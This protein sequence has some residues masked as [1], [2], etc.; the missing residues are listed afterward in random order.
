MTPSILDTSDEAREPVKHCS[1]RSR[2]HIALRRS[3]HHANDNMAPRAPHH[4]A[5]IRQMVRP[6]RLD[7]HRARI[8]IHAREDPREGRGARAA[9]RRGVVDVERGAWRE[10]GARGGREE[11]CEEGACEC[12]VCQ[13]GERCAGGGVG[14]QCREGDLGGGVPGE[15]GGCEAFESCLARCAAV[16]CS[17]SE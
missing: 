17:Q 2:V 9:R 12:G 15:R 14:G 3:V 13:C 6:A 1:L 4:A 10:D 5:L 16:A 11:R 7:V 8:R